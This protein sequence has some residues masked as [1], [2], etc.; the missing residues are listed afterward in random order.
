MISKKKVLP[1]QIKMLPSGKYQ[2]IFRFKVNNKHKRQRKA[3]HTVLLAQKWLNKKNSEN[4]KQKYLGREYSV[5]FIDLL[6]YYKREV[7]KSMHSLARD[8]YIYKRILPWIKSNNIQY[9]NQ[10]TKPI[11][12][13]YEA[14]R[15]QFKTLTNK[16]ISA[17][18]IN[19][20]IRLISAILSH[21]VKMD[22]IPYNP[23]AN[24][25]YKS[26]FKPFGRFLKIDE[27]LKILN[28]ADKEEFLILYT[29]LTTGI[30]S[31]ECCYL[32]FS[33]VNNGTIHIRPKLIWEIIDGKKTTR[34][35]SPKWGKERFISIDKD[36]L[37]DKFL[38]NF[39]EKNN[40][41]EYCFKQ[42]GYNDGRSMNRNSF[43]KRVKKVILRSGIDNAKEITPH[44]LKHTHISY[45]VSRIGK[46]IRLSLPLIMDCVGDNDFKTLK[47]YTQAVRNLSKNLPNP[48]KLPWQK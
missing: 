48:N 1:P 42:P 35:W 10:I 25:P 37:D 13:Q 33:D 6:E 31:E 41:N 11:I 7:K 46:D 44:T 36:Y 19:I 24:Y 17:R 28:A 22:R 39:F 16:N 4:D 40:N 47:R 32:Q 20:D 23:L 18:T 45:L 38:L 2:A 43:Y 27:V 5:L 30:R 29:L 9:V 8:K 26:E 34:N 21:N 12:A 14:Y 15:S 3:F